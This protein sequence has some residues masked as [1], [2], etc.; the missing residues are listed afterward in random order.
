MCRSI[1]YVSSAA[2]DLYLSYEAMLDLGIIPADFPSI[3]GATLS[4]T[5]AATKAESGDPHTGSESQC[6]CPKREMPPPLPDRLPFEC[7]PEN[8]E[9]MKEWLL[10]RYASSTFNKCT[11]QQLPA[12]DG[13]PLGN[14]YG[15]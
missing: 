12:M 3:G 9:R 6:K 14:T 8:N 13:P 11:H 2:S 4:G 10:N 15:S 1:I 7:I 5:Q